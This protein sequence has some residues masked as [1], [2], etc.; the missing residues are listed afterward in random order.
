MSRECVICVPAR[1]E[2]HH[3]PLLLTGLANQ[4]LPSGEALRV[5]VLANN[6]SDQ[7]AQVARRLGDALPQLR[8]RIREQDWPAGIANVGLARGAAMAAGIAWLR[9]EVGDGI[10]ISTDADAI[11][12][13]HWLSAIRHGFR[14][15]AEVVGGE[16]RIDDGDQP[17][18]PDWLRAARARVGAY[19]AAVRELAHAIDPLPH[20]PPGCH[21]NHTGAS[22]AITLN[23]Y[24][25]AGG[26]PPIPSREDIALVRAVERQ[27]GRVRHPAAVWTVAS[28]RETG[29]AEGG[30]ADELRRWR[31]LA[32]NDE[33][34]LVPAAG[35]WLAVFLRRRALRNMYRQRSFHAE[36]GLPV[37]DLMAIAA[38]SVN[39]IAFVAA[40]EDI[41]ADA[42]ATTGEIG[43]V[44]RELRAMLVTRSAA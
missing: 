16:I 26:I 11:P 17:A 22:L 32:E 15:G 1:N 31:H 37:A 39:D 19:W 30:M 10:L 6:C 27:G 23:A 3:L 18:V 9:E 29:R 21:G 20:D 8:L 36:S 33:P 25:A 28:A 14:E 24:Q 44:T 38:R 7:T 41:V 42:Q 13:P 35:H 12:P 43:R 5:V 34:H 2:E 4:D 40:C